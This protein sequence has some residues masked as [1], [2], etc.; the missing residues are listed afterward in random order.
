[1]SD[2][3]LDKRDFVAMSEIEVANLKEAWLTTPPT[4][5]PPFGHLVLRLIAT[6]EQARGAFAL[7]N[8]KWDEKEARVAELEDQMATARW[9]LK[10]ST[11][12]SSHNYQ[13]YAKADAECDELKSK[14]TATNATLEQVAQLAKTNLDKKDNEI[15]DLKDR[16]SESLSLFEEMKKL[17]KNGGLK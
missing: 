14:L 11:E 15:C 4:K 16:L 8:R 3:T 12:T 9:D 7:A 1:M 5:L 6:V 10:M 2:Q 17:S 13:R